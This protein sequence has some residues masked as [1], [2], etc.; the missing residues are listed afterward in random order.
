MYISERASVSR[1]L[2]R[3]DV[4]QMHSSCA[5]APRKKPPPGS[6]GLAKLRATVFAIP[7]RTIK[8]WQAPV[9]VSQVNS[10]S[11]AHEVRNLWLNL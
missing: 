7:S 10:I 6:C 9:V 3:I 1:T 2:Y 5:R 8:R 11:P 4:R